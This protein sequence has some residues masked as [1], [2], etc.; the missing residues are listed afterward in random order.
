MLC[1]SLVFKTLFDLG[2]KSFPFYSF[3]DDDSVRQAIAGSDIVINL[4]GKHYETKHMIPTRRSDGSLSR[5]GSPRR[6]CER[7]SSSV[8]F[9]ST[10]LPPLRVNFSFDKVNR[11]IPG[12]IA[13]HC[14]ELGVRQVIVSHCTRHIYIYVYS[15]FSSSLVP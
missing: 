10:Y 1:C 15:T 2:E 12:C 7:S 3:N 8:L 9:S 6:L 13:K 4:V 14:C 5:L 11:E